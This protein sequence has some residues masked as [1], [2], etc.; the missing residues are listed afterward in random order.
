MSPILFIH[1]FGEDR[2]IWDDFV[3][4]FDW[5]QEIDIIDYSNW[6][7][8]GSIAA[9]AQKIK[10]IVKEN[11]YH[12]VGHSMGGYIA[13]E[14]AKQFPDFVSSVIMLNST[15]RA[16]NEE[17][18]ANRLKT[19]EFLRVHGTKKFISSF[20]PNMFAKSKLEQHQALIVELT[21]R[22]KLLS[23]EALA[24]ATEAMK[25]RNDFQEFLKETKIPFLFIAGEEDS[26]FSPESI[27]EY[28]QFPGSKHSLVTLPQ[29]GH[30]ATYEAPIA[31]QYLIAEFISQK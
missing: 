24:N 10:E 22:F 21:E 1:G 28:L 16:D 30:H 14:L 17:K 19:I 18:K 25:N 2:S 8:C 11:H 7:D 23:N 29:V 9:Y 26:F 4:S 6:V 31:V 5:D 27:L 20:L 13:L 15:A 12:L 3:Y